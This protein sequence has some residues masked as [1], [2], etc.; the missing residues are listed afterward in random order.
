MLQEV[1]MSSQ[2]NICGIIVKSFCPLIK[3][4]SMQMDESLRLKNIYTIDVHKLRHE[5]RGRQ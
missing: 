3:I 1:S 2:L 4:T 5:Q